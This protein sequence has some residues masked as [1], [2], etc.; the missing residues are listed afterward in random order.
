MQME[1]LASSEWL[2]NTSE[3]ATFHVVGIG[4]ALVDVIAHADEEFSRSTNW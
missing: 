4:N 2:S 3:E 1:P